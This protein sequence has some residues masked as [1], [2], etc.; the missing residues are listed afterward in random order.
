MLQASPVSLFFILSAESYRMDHEKVARLPFAFAFGYCINF[1][2]YATLQT[3][4][5]GH[6]IAA[7]V[8][9]TA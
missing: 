3:R 9:S 5:V 4:R 6:E 7:R 1:C 2:I 8:R